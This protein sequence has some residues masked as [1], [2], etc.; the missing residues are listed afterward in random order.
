MHLYAKQEKFTAIEAS[1]LI[2]R[3]KGIDVRDIK[4][5]SAGTMGNAPFLQKITT[6]D[7]FDIGSITKSFVTV[8]ILQLH[9]QQKLSLD[10]P[11][12][13]WLPQYTQWSKVTLRQLLNMTSGI[14]NYS[15]DSGFEKKMEANWTYVWTD[16]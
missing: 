5:F 15:E 14:P 6:N 16:E 10:D 13:K 1:V 12:G 9:T 4:N 11:L 8:L 2:P 3:D 7:L